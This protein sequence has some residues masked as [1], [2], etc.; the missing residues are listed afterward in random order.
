MNQTERI[1]D[2]VAQLIPAILLTFYVFAI[3][4]AIS[5]TILAARQCRTNA[6]C[7]E[8]FHARRIEGVNLI[9]N[10]VG[11]LVSALVVTEL[12]ITQP[13]ELPSA[14]ILKRRETKSAKRVATILSTAFI[15]VWLLGGA[16]SVL[17]Y[18]L[19]PNATPS[20]L[21]EFA[22]AWLGL[23]LASAY[24]YLGIR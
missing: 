21:S 17:M 2:V 24:S 15:I 1:R 6:A 16:A 11:G 20:A 5:S 4:T 12:A 7:A 10:L 8:T 3:G 14:Q 23:A 13:G 19:Y 22:K 9:L 18:V